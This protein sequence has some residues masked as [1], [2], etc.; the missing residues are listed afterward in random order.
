MK[1]ILHSSLFAAGA[2]LFRFPAATTA[3]PSFG[4]KLPNGERVPCRDGIDSGCID[5]Y[6][7]G[8]GHPACDGGTSGASPQLLS[9]FGQDWKDAGFRWTTELCQA[10]SDGDGLTNGEE[11]GDPCCV[12]TVEDE[13]VGWV[14]E[15]TR[16]FVPSH[17]GDAD[18]VLPEGYERPASCDAE[19]MV[20]P[21]GEGGGSVA[22]GTAGYNEGEERGSFDFLIKDYPIPRETTTYVDFV[23]NLPEDLPDVV[24]IVYGEA[25]VSQP[26]HLHHFVLQGCT[27]RIDDE[28]EG[29]PLTEVPSD[30][31]APIGGFTGWA[32]GVTMWDLPL[33]AGV[34]I[35]KQF[36]VQ[37][38]SVN[39]HYTDGDAPFLNGT[40][41]IANDGIRIHYTPTLRPK[42]V[43]S[44][45]VIQV[46]FGPPDMVVEPNKQRAFMTRTCT[47]ETR[48]HDETDRTMGI[49]GAA[50]LD[51]PELTCA[52]VAAKNLCESA[53]VLQ[54]ACP[55][56]CGLCEEG[57]PYDPDSFRAVGVFYH[58][59]LLG[60]EMYTTLIPQDDPT[61]RIDLK[62]RNIWTYED[63]TPYTLDNVLVRPG[64]KI[65]TTCVFDSTGRNESTKF[66]LATY[67]EMCLNTVSVMFDTPNATDDGGLSAANDVYLRSFRCS[68]AEDGD[69]W[70][71]EFSLD[72]DPR[73]VIDTHPLE[74]VKCSFPTGVW[75]MDSVPTMEKR[76][77]GQIVQE[78]DEGICRDLVLNPT[79]PAGYTCL[80]GLYRDKDSNDGTTEEECT[81]GGGVWESYSCG[82]A[83]ALFQSPDSGFEL[84]TKEYLREYWWGPKCCVGIAQD[85]DG[86][87]DASEVES[88][89]ASIM[90]HGTSL[91]VV[92]MLVM[93]NVVTL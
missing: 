39:V 71:G 25:L 8:I 32:P 27:S 17:P 45:P 28:L 86:S 88:S 59:H 23:F 10:D 21:A 7:R 31:N 16:N 4:S 57:S 9:P 58:A 24:H 51:D 1:L 29:T 14:S 65:Q 22:L 77:D 81:G 76:C 78:T 46:G 33:N 79:L 93:I 89:S 72:E 91:F 54:L 6:C 5:G 44:N 38:V 50:T 61:A 34:P 52:S 70:Q 63:Q 30:C 43:V 49:I 64:D 13:A 90:F 11:L 92:G 42:T 2:V 60:K 75:I 87:G 62:S 18:H 40:Q 55:E 85:G 26:K 35:G 12:W 74:D 47:V 3:L 36:G 69:I 80:G 53:D 82:D 56:S 20:V 41:A 19:E 48:C 84:G 67:D 73:D 83:Q 37:A 66:A 15:Y 68:T